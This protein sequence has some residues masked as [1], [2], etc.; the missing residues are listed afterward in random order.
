MV[1]T[2]KNIH[3]GRD[4]RDCKFGRYQYRAATYFSPDTEDFDC[5]SGSSEIRNVEAV[6]EYLEGEI[7]YSFAEVCPCFQIKER[8]PLSSPIESTWDQEYLKT[9]GWN[10]FDDI[11][12]MTW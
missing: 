1:F 9:L 11:Q 3:S 8:E 12:D 6:V 2:A 5:I 7:N 4:C 10:C